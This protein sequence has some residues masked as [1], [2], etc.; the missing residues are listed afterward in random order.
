MNE[1]ALR[2][3]VVSVGAEMYARDFI[4][5]PAGNISTRLP[6]GNLLITPSGVNKGKLTPE[7][8]LVIDLDGNCLQGN[9]VCNPTSELPM[10]LE[11]YHR[12]PD[13]GAVIH[14]HPITCVALSLVGI[15]LQDS[16]IPEALVMLGPIPTAPYATPSSAENRDAIAG[17]IV[18]HDAIIL[19]HHGTLTVGRDLDEACTRLEILEHTAKTV[20]QAY[21][22]GQ[23]R[24]LS[25]KAIEKLL[26]QRQNMGYA[27][28]EESLLSIKIAAEVERLTLDLQDLRW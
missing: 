20:A 26:S 27:H 2:I 4:S 11:V 18:D 16:Y 21:Q 5:G 25:R 14:A 17:L 13:V 19:A 9:V 23:P 22:L 24:Q 28:P 8:L 15:S 1:H 6:D 10:H 12:R 7:Q 3:W